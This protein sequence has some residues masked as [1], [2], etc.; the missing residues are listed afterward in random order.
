MD[1][2]I[3]VCMVGS[4]PQPTGGMS[5]LCFYE[6]QHLA[7]LGVKVHFVDTGTGSEKRVP[8]LVDHYTRGNSYINTVLAFLKYPRK[9][10]WIAIQI[11]LLRKNLLSYQDYLWT[12]GVASKTLIVAGS[13]KCSL[14]HSY[15]AI[16]RSLAAV[17]VAESLRI[18]SVVT[19]LS[20]EFTHPGICP[21]RKTMTDY[22]ISHADCLIA[23]SKFTQSVCERSSGKRA[24]VIYPGVD[25]KVFY[26]CDSATAKKVAD[27]YSLENYRVLLY[28][29]RLVPEKGVK[30]LL[31]AFSLLQNQQNH[32]DVVCV[33][34]GPDWG[35]KKDV[36]DYIDINHL[37]DKVFVWNEIS[38]SDLRSLYS[39]AD[40]F[41]LPT[42]ME[43]EG[44]GLAAAEAMACGTPVVASR[45]AA[46]PEVVQDRVTGLLFEPRNAVDLASKLD[47]LL[48]NE[49][50]RRKLAR[51]AHQWVRD[52]FSW[53]PSA[54]Q[55]LDLYQ[56]CLKDLDKNT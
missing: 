51:Q 52:K 15:H 46:V 26:P 24:T 10:F 41:I 49:E 21:I 35:A 50:Y 54:Q 16:G 17:L 29:G 43:V 31:E 39:M 55:I 38:L 42:V 36:L 9:L 30:V 53:E 56:K 48:G 47:I 18:P 11:H 8:P 45:I 13:N 3:T 32:Q 2:K 14:I 1:P 22:I 40:V 6:A 5:T 23:I 44:F 33:I 34:I 12:L 19:V 7:H 37:K 20:S 4:F 28:V 25:T 27:R